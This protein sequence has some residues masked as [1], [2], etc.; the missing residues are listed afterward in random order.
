MRI[1]LDLSNETI[2]DAVETQRVKVKVALDLSD[3]SL[4]DV[5]ETQRV[6][7]E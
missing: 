4:N 2:N 6:K 5:I 1:A 7:Y 3:E